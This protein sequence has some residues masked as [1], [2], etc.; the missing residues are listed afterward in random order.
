ME[1]LKT[2]IAVS[3]YNQ[4]QYAMLTNFLNKITFFCSWVFVY[5]AKFT[6]YLLLQHQRKS[7]N[8]LIYNTIRLMF[9]SIIHKLECLFILL[10]KVFVNNPITYAH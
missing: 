5:F 10:T 1:E 3:I 6:L 2:W 8:I 4:M 9:Y 7:K